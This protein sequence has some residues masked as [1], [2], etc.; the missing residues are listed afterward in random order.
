MRI[1]ERKYKRNEGG[2][3]DDCGGGGGGGGGEGD[4]GVR[5]LEGES[6]VHSTAEE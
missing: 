6:T 2:E 1:N 5:Q 3:D 4:E